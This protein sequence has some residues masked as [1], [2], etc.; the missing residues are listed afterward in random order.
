[1]QAV[2]V[3]RG[4]DPLQ[5][6]VGVEVLRQRQL[7]DVAVAGRIGVELVDQRLDLILC[8]VCGQLALDR[9]HAD[10]L[11]LSMLHSD[12]ELRG[13][14][15]AHEHGRDAGDDAALLERGDALGAARP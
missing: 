7:H 6:R 12:V 13:R 14:I 1:M 5:D 9:V 3:L 15:R 11:G 10:R 4:I 2:G 8:R